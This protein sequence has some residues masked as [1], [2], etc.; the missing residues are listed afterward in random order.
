MSYVR[1]LKGFHAKTNK[2]LRCLL[3]MRQY[4]PH[5][6][7]VCSHYRNYQHILT[8][9]RRQTDVSA[10]HISLIF[11]NCFAYSNANIM[12]FVD[13]KCM[14]IYNIMFFG[15]SMNESI[16]KVFSKLLIWNQLLSNAVAI[17]LKVLWRLIATDLHIYECDMRLFYF[18]K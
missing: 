6:Y 15:K 10:A 8:V 4:G 2:G 11:W 16:W 1:V 7:G 3:P 14:L 9:F 18:W 17:H 13:F 12:L 5:S